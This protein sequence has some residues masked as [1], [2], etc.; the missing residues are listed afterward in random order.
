MTVG[1]VFLAE[2]GVLEQQTLLLCESLR[3]FGGRYADAAI[4]ILQP[5][6]ERAISAGVRG[7]LEKLGA[8]VVELALV[9]P[10]PEYGPSYR[11]FACAEHEPSSRSDVFVFMDSDTVLLAE[12]D[13]ELH[14]AD[15]A[16]RPVDVPG[17]C[18]SG[19][20]DPNESYWRELCELCAVDYDQI[21]HVITTVKHIRVRA[22]Y[23]GG[24]TVVKRK[25]GLFAKA[26][27][28]FTA[29]LRTNLI[30]RPILKIPFAAGHGNVSEAGAQLWGSSQACL[31]LAITA[32][33]LRVRVL[34]PAQNFPLNFYPQL[35]GEIEAGTFPEISHV[36]Y[37]HLFRDHPHDNPILAG[38]PGFPPESIGWLRE[39]AVRFA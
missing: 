2:S 32:L 3:M 11:V 30:P 36:H 17:M 10:C 29:S 28:F 13:L 19:D 20:G 9:S 31:S 12:P 33:G 23:N 38:L 1:F 7:E 5:R 34:S 6:P 18:T 24:L 15:V 4:T 37:H 39:R 8:A 14:D 26:A 22:S 21:P 16:V 25:A 35:R 27:E